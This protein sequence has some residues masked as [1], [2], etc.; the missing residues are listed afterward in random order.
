MCNY[1][2]A[3][4]QCTTWSSLT[5]QASVRRASDATGGELGSG[6][7]GRAGELGLPG[8]GG[9]WGSST[10]GRPPTSSERVVTG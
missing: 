8:E 2:S 1:P 5:L 3:R 9:V 4:K 7:E 10:G 6:G